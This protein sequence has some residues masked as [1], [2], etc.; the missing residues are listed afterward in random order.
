MP[1]RYSDIVGDGGSNIVGEAACAS[2]LAAVDLAVRELETGRSK[3]AIAGGV[4]TQ[5]CWG[6]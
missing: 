1:K 4:D 6:W 2:T 3:L 5:R